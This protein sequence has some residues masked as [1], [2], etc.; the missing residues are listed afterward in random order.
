MD[1]LI[2]IY[3]TGKEQQ[4]F[5]YWGL[6]HFYHAYIVNTLSVTALC[7]EKSKSL[8]P[9]LI[10]LKEMSWDVLIKYVIYIKVPREIQS[11]RIDMIDFDYLKG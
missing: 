11:Q 6:L 7:N 4:Y 1:F 9:Y 2:S 3:K 5:T 8:K 10:L